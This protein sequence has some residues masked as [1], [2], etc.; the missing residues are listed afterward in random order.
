MM[1]KKRKYSYKKAEHFA[2]VQLEYHGS[3]HSTVVLPDQGQS[4][5]EV[6]LSIQNDISHISTGFQV[7]EVI[8]RLPKF[9]MEYEVELNNYLKNLGMKKA[10]DRTDLSTPFP[11]LSTPSNLYIDRVIHKTFLEVNEQGA[12]AAAITAIKMKANMV[13]KK[14]QIIEMTVN[15]PFLFLIQDKSGHILFLGFIGA[16]KY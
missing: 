12:E 4:I 9:K 6:L 7:K 14:E 8:L 1:Y 15:R 16:P 2:A 3:I 13:V 5:Q 11:T 10:F